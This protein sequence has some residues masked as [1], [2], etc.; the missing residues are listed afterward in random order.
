[1]KFNVG[2]YLIPYIHLSFINIFNYPILIKNY[3]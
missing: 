3:L 2:I 1:M